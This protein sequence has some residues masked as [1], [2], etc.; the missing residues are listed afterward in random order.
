MSQQNAN[1]VNIVGGT[2]TGITDLTVADGG[3]GASTAAGARTNLELGNIAVMNTSNVA[4]IGGTANNIV[5]TGGSIAGLVT[6]LAVDSGGTGGNTQA[7]A[8]SGIGLGSIS[9]QNANS[10]TITGGNISGLTAPLEISSGGTGGNTQANARSSLGLGT[11]ATQNSNSVTIVGGTISGITSLSAANAVITSGT[12]TGITDLAIADGG[13][14]GSTAAEA[15][16]NLGTAASATQVIAGNGLSGGGALTT[17]VTLTIATNSNGFGVRYV[18]TG[19]PV[20]GS[21]GDIWY[22]I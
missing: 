12:I 5:I 9:T 6:P 20:G 8:R 3:T 7:S 10:I 11:I 15:R 16:T 21:N 17:N 19:A 1:A 13:T 2:I 14:G 22:Q 4:F 18:S